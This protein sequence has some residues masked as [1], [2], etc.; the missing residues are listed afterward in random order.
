MPV[1]QAPR[2]AVTDVLDLTAEALVA[3][4]FTLVDITVDLLTPHVHPDCDTID[5]DSDPQPLSALHVLRVG[6][7]PGPE[8]WTT[9]PTD[10]RGR[11]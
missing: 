2:R 11:P 3:L 8:T 6:P 10:S 9:T 1:L 4:A 7:P 5:H